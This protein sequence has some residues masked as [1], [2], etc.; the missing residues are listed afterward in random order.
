MI[1]L[2]FAN[3]FSV[4]LPPGGVWYLIAIEIIGIDV[5]LLVILA[6]V[7]AG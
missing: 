1:T 2:L 3:K 7:V 4:I 6:H 5:T